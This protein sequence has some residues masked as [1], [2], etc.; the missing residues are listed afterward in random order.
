M[1]KI[2]A[3]VLVLSMVLGSFGFAFA[4]TPVQTN[5]GQALKDLGV[6]KGDA[7]GN[8]MLDSVL[9]RQDIIVLLSRLM[10]A[11]EEAAKFPIPTAFTDV[12]DAYYKPFIGWATVEGLTNG[13]GENKF[14]FDQELTVKELA[15][16]LLRAL[17]NDNAWDKAEALSVEL[18]LVA[19]G[20]NFNAAASRGVMAAA[21]LNALGTAMNGEKHSLGTHLGLAGFE[22]EQ[23]VVFGVKSVKANTAKS[24]QVEFTKAVEDTSKI[25]FTAKRGTAT[26]NITT[27]WNADKTVATLETATKLAEGIYTVA[28]TD[29]GE[30]KVEIEKEK[31]AVVEY[32]SETIVRISDEEGIVGYTVRNQ[33]G[34]DITDAALGRGLDW[35]VSTNAPYERDPKIG[36][37]KVKH[38]GEA[39]NKLKD[40]KTVVVTVRDVST[41]FV[42][43]KSFAVSDT[44]SIVSDIK[45]LGIVDEKGNDV[46]FIFDTTKAYYLDY[47]AF[48]ING[49]KIDYY[50]ALITKLYQTNL[51]NTT[52]IDPNS[53]TKVLD[54]RGSNDTYISVDIDRHPDNSSRA[55]FRITLKT[56]TGPT[57]DQPVSFIAMAPFTGKTSTLNTNLLRKARVEAFSIQSPTEA[58]S[59]GKS[60]EIPFTALDNNGNAITKHE[61]L[62]GKITF[63][64]TNS[65]TNNISFVRQ[66]DG[67]TKL[68]GR[69][70]AEGMKYITATVD[71]SLTG[72]FTQISIDIKKLAKPTTIDALKHARAYT[73]SAKWETRRINHFAIRDQFDRV[74]N[75]RTDSSATGYSVR[76]I[77][78][79][80]LVVGINTIG[81]STE[82]ISGDTA[83]DFIGGINAG[84]ATI[85]YELLDAAG[86]VVDRASTVVYN[87]SMDDVRSVKIVKDH[88]RDLYMTANT[89]YAKDP[90]APAVKELRVGE[91]MNNEFTMVGLLDNGGMEV[92]IDRTAAALDFISNDARFTFDGAKIFA[93]KNFGTDVTATTTVTGYVYNKYGVLSA[94][95]E[96]KASSVAP[97]ATQV[98]VTYNNAWRRSGV[99]NVD[100]NVIEVSATNLMSSDYF[101]GRSVFGYRADGT[102]AVQ[103]LD[104]GVY[105]SGPTGINAAAL[106]FWANTQYGADDAGLL[107]NINVVKNTPTVN[108]T[109]QINPLT[110]IMTVSN[111]VAQGAEFTI[112]AIANGA[113]KTVV[114]KVK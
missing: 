102:P 55:V 87:V 108:G 3:L 7:S 74:M 94:S 5:A 12:T 113:V 58:A 112:T 92:R 42:Q 53:G 72:S 1:K 33:Y 44:V 100:N 40:L 84:T 67:T 13:I 27:K 111:D 99:I 47:E 64:P 103:K 75:L 18:G 107:T 8:L 16:F 6:L 49:K 89:N 26:A 9:K 80:P 65:S 39:F 20:T 79:A 30:F 73:T 91:L 11:E 17:G 71:G 28:V 63:S 31:V 23:P 19:A 37:L 14:G 77:S 86:V 22:L 109:V 4:A 70:D 104:N 48:D 85:T 62:A 35:I 36:V 56:T 2:L 43:T 101:N 66:A 83:I 24:F 51:P 88:N 45:L 52:T 50:A 38:T 82:T 25:T 93:D 68:F 69:F 41:G 97:V 46:E 105:V 21:T 76:I 32:D 81:N 90:A 96:V 10:G 106:R 15:T 34:E 98:N 95:A 61:D 114:I 54:V 110:G 29:L 60:F 59:V 78:S 57:Y